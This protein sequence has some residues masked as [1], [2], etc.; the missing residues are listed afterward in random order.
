M[1]RHS[2]EEAAKTR[3]NILRVAE[4]VFA[5]NGFD[6]AALS[7]IAEQAA[8]S[9]S[10][11][12][13]HFESKERLWDEV[14]LQGFARYVAEQIDT[15]ANDNDGYTFIRKSCAAYFRYLEKNPA[16]LRMMQWSQAER[17][18]SFTGERDAQTAAALEQLVNEGARRVSAL[19]LQGELRDDLD[20]RLLIACFL[21]LVR[22]WF[23]IR[24]DYFATAKNAPGLDD[25]YLHTVITVFW[26][27]IRPRPRK[28]GE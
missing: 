22:Q 13:H 20:P 1:G 2:R 9:K 28:P 14:R 21:G 11:I 26:D 17:G 23:V 18:R 12:H 27:G 4:R 24:E 15:L 16:V 19:Q 5:T 25:E 3:E 7:A 8:V 10:L 6:G